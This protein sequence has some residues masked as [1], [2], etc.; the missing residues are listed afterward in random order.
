M[1]E[2]GS[3]GGGRLE[4]PQDSRLLGAAWLAPEDSASREGGVGEGPGS[5]GLMKVSKNACLHFFFLKT[6]CC[7]VSDWDRALR[8]IVY[9]SK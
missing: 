4:V 3:R 2:G 7:L 9:I 1:D 5:A 6:H 8:C